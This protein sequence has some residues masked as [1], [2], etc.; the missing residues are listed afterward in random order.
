MQREENIPQYQGIYAGEKY[1]YAN[2][3]FLFSRGRVKQ[4]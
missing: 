4:L 2:Q 3:T 1:F